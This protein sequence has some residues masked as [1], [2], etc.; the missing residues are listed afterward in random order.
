[1]LFQLSNISVVLKSVICNEI[2]STDRQIYFFDQN[3]SN[4]KFLRL[5]RCS[6]LFSFKAYNYLISRVFLPLCVNEIL[7]SNLNNLLLR[8]KNQYINDR[9]SSPPFLSHE[10]QT[11]QIAI[12][13]NLSRSICYWLA[14][15]T[16]C[17][18]LVYFSFNYVLNFQNI[19]TLC[20]CGVVHENYISTN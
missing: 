7:P 1:M 11:W 14:S 8:L 2:L 4:S 9:I 5:V 20:K 13:K 6:L 10:E 15:I 17:I 12:R 16:I 19:L 3:T 18:V